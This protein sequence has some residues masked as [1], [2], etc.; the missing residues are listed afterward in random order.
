MRKMREQ[1]GTSCKPFW[2][3]VR[4]KRKQRRLN[5]MKHEEEDEV[6]E[7]IARHREELGRKEWEGC[8]LGMYDE[9]SNI[10]IP[11]LTS[12]TH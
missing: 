11:H 3:D 5:R 4:G 1:G 8:K 10:S 12:P 7:V 9:A 6:L 2:T